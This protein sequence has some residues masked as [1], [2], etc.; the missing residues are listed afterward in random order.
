MAGVK[1]CSSHRERAVVL[2]GVR[3]QCHL[4][5]GLF[6]WISFPEL[7]CLSFWAVTEGCG[8][9]G[10]RWV[11]YA[12]STWD[13]LG[14]SWRNVVPFPNIPRALPITGSVLLCHHWQKLNEVNDC[15]T[16][17]LLQVILPRTKLGYIS[18]GGLP[19]AVPVLVTQ[20]SSCFR[21]KKRVI[22]MGI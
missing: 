11:S 3:G 5:P 17:L 13:A 2:Q 1:A 22:A 12:K 4:K 18:R 10:A 16:F 15:T 9:P 8:C 19:V 7:V 21:D 14:G 6:F 20:V